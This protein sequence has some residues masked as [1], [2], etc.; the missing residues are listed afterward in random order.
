MFL[1][2]RNK[3][4]FLLFFKINNESLRTSLLLISSKMLI[5]FQ[6]NTLEHYYFDLT[7]LRIIT[8]TDV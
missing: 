2:E 3:S 4:F 1:R 5:N 8:E 7:L 6:K